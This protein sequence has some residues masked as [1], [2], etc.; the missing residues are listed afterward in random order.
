MEIS[1]TAGRVDEGRNGATHMDGEKFRSR[2]F[3]IKKNSRFLLFLL[4]VL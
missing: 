1:E 4:V 2:N 3:S